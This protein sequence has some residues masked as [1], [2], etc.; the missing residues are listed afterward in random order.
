M[1]EV[2]VGRV[3]ANTV[4][5]VN[6][7]TYKLIKFEASFKPRA[8]ALHQSRFGYNNIPN[9]TAIPEN[10][11]KWITDNSYNIDKLYEENEVV[12]IGKWVDRFTKSYSDFLLFFNATRLNEPWPLIILHTGHGSALGYILHKENFEKTTNWFVGYVKMFL[13]GEIEHEPFDIFPIHLSVSCSTGDFTYDGG[14]C[15]GEDF[16]LTEKAGASA[17]IFHSNYSFYSSLNAH[18]YSGQF[19]ER[20]FYQLFQNGIEQLGKINQFAKEDLKHLAA[21]D[22]TYRWC[23]YTINLLGDP[24]TPVLTKRGKTIEIE[25]VS[26]KLFRATALLKNTGEQDLAD[27]QWVMGF[28]CI[29]P[30]WAAGD[31]DGRISNLKV[32]QTYKVSTLQGTNAGLLFELFSPLRIFVGARTEYSNTIWTVKKGIIF[33]P[34]VILF[35]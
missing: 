29:L 17:C 20:Q 27:I 35:K 30:R 33:G 11:S 24:E 14:R 18:E 34:F 8:V 22:T 4:Q 19:Y 5:D 31:T 13:G 21:N 15:L 12:T 1:A 32:G 6:N 25:K 3:P 28:S 16:L 7:F 2:Y 9:S 26:G 23:Y 10:C